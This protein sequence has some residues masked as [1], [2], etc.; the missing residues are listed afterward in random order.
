MARGQVSL[1]RNAFSND[2]SRHPSHNST[3]SDAPAGGH[4]RL[5]LGL[6]PDHSWSSMTA[7]SLVSRDNLSARSSV[8]ADASSDFGADDDSFVQ[9]NTEISEVQDAARGS[10]QSERELR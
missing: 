1:D 2:S 8:A 4:G 3:G 10:L 7:L 6:V 9:E 5:G